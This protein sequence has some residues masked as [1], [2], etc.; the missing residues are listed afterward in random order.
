MNQFI[1]KQVIFLP[2]REE[3][4]YLIGHTGNYLLIKTPG[5]KEEINQDLKVKIT[6]TKYPYSFAKR[7]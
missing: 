3:D 5:T 7:I 2:E 1:G 4:G 6:E